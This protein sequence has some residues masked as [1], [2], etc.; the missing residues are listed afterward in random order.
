MIISGAKI[1]QRHPELLELREFKTRKAIISALK[2]GGKIYKVGIFFE[3]PCYIA[4]PVKV[5][6]IKKTK[7]D[8][9]VFVFQQKEEPLISPFLY[10]AQNHPAK[11]IFTSKKRASNFFKAAKKAFRK[12]NEWQIEANTEYQSLFKTNGLLDAFY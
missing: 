7:K 1:A 11:A 5:L 8:G 9:Y 2:N 6:R 12:D 3:K 10:D 4:G